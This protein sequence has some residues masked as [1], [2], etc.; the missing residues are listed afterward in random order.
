[1][2]E[3]CVYHTSKS[4]AKPFSPD[5]KNRMFKF[6]APGDAKVYIYLVTKTV[7]QILLTKKEKLTQILR[8]S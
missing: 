7:P 4:R 8:D 2:R 1:M 5:L 6:L 3:N